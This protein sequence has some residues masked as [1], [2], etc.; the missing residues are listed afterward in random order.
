MC[1]RNKIRKAM[2]LSRGTR[3]LSASASARKQRP[4]LGPATHQRSLQQSGNS[5]LL[6]LAMF[7]AWLSADVGC[8]LL[9]VCKSQMGGWPFLDT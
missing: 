1:A 4:S 7:A 6:L 9:A 8:Y 5:S 2:G 3:G